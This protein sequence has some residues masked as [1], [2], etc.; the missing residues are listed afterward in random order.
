[1]LLSAPS[2]TSRV[3][4]RELVARSFRV[5]AR[6]RPGG[7]GGGGGGGGDGGDVLQSDYPGLRF[8]ISC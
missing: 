6:P 3:N 7:G 2:L 4:R 1:M 8:V 5:A